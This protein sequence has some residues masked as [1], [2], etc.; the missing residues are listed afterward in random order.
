[1]KVIDVGAF[2]AKTHLSR[3]LDEVEG[4]ALVRI[5][6][7]GRVVAVLKADEKVARQSALDALNALQSLTTTKVPVVTVLGLRDEGRER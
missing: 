7:R 6:R 3:L 5:S 4:G 1:M 2:E